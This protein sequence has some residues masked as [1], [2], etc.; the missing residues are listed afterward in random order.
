MVLLKREGM[1]AD[2][3]VQPDAESMALCGIPYAYDVL[4][5]HFQQ[6]AKLLSLSVDGILHG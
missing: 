1:P 4:F 3:K 5:R 2:S 6:I